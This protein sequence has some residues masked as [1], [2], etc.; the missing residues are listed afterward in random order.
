MTRLNS[1]SPARLSWALKL[2]YTVFLCVLVPKYWMDYGPTNFLYFC[3]VALFMTLAAV[4]FESSLWA[5]AAAVGILMPQS[6]WMADFLGSLFSLPLTGMTAYMFDPGIPAFTRGLSFFHFWLPILL[7]YLVFRLGYHAGA[8][9]LWT[10]IA[11]VLLPVCYFCLPAP[12]APESNPNLPV[13]VNYVYGPSDQAPQ[14]WVPPLAWLA[15]LMCGLPLC[16]YLPT[17]L[18]LQRCFRAAERPVLETC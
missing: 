11:W 13:N 10:V 8:L 4:W 16:L 1:G 12:P 17:H 2:A 7:V 5:S 9:R 14:D 15:A 3:D 18:L 6:L